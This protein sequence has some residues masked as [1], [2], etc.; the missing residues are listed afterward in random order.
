[1]AMGIIMLALAILALTLLPGA[2]GGTIVGDQPP[3][4]GEWLIRQDT[5]VTDSTVTVTGPVTIEADLTLMGS[6]LRISVGSSGMSGIEV[7]TGN[8]MANDSAIESGNGNTYEFLV[9]S[10]MNLTRVTVKGAHM[11]IY[12]KTKKDVL[13]DDVLITDLHGSALR[14]E[15]AD[16]TVVKDLRVHDDDYDHTINRTVYTD[17]VNGFA[18]LTESLPGILMIMGGS[19]TVGTVDISING[20]VYYNVIFHQR[21][22][23][24]GI[25]I[26]LKWPM[27]DVDTKDAI[28]LN[29]ITVRDSLLGLNCTVSSAESIPLRMTTD[30]RWGVTGVVFRNYRDAKIV[31]LTFPNLR[32]DEIFLNVTSVNPATSLPFSRVDWGTRAVDAYVDETFDRR[33]PHSFVLELRDIYLRG[34][35]LLDHRLVPGYTGS[36]SPTFN[37]KVLVDNAT[38]WFGHEPIKF[39]LE[40]TFKMLKT[41]NVD[42][43]LS[44]CTFTSLM[45]TCVGFEY[46]TGPPIPMTRSIQLNERTV[47]ENCRFTRNS[48]DEEGLVKTTTN[49]GFNNVSNSSLT[50]SNSTFT[51]N[52]GTLFNIVGT[53]NPAHD[54]LVLDGNWISNNGCWRAQ[55][56]MTVIDVSEVVILNNTFADN[57]CSNGIYISDLGYKGE[58]LK[59]PCSFLI[60]NNSFNRNWA[61][62]D[63]GPQRGFI[64]VIW[65]GDLVVR[66]NLINGTGSMFLNLTEVTNYSQYSTLD[67]EDN[68]VQWNKDV[69]LYFQNND[70][71]HRNLVVSVLNNTVWDNEGALVDFNLDGNMVRLYDYDATFRLVGNDVRRARSTVFSNYGNITISDNTFTDCVG[72]VLELDYLR[73]QRPYLTNNTFTRCGDTIFIKAK[74]NV[75]APILIWMD[76]NVIDTNGTA[77]YFSQMEVTLRTTVITSSTGQAVVAHLS[78]VDAYDCDFEMDDCEVV[79]DGYIKM[80]YWVEAWVYWASKEGV[81]TTNPVIDGNVTFR[82]QAGLDSVVAYPDDTGHLEPAEVLAWHIT[83]SLAPVL[84]NPYTIMVSLSSFQ[85]SVVQN[86]SRSYKGDNALFLY[87]WDP[88]DPL[89]SI[90]GPVDMSAHNTLDVNIT[91]FVTDRGSGVHILTIQIVGV[92]SETV[93]PEINGSYLHVLQDVPEGLFEI[94]ATVSD[95][96][97]NTMSVSI[98]IE[99]DRTPPRLVVTH[100][101]GELFTNTTQVNIRGEVEIGTELIINMIEHD[102]STGVIDLTFPL[103]EGVNYFGLTA[104]DRAGNAANVVIWVTRDTF[105]PEL[106]LFGPSD[107]ASVNVSDVRVFGLAVDFDTLTITLH[108][109]FTD[110][111]DRP[112]FPNAEGAFDVMA[113]LEEGTNEIVVTAS[114]K[115]GNSITI[116]RTVTMDTTPPLLEL[117]SPADNTLLNVHQVTVVLTVSDDADQVYV[118]G[119]RVL[120]TGDLETVVTLG[121]GENPITIRA[122]DTLW[123]EASTSIMVYTDTVAPT[124]EITEPNVTVIMTND[125][126]IEVRGRAIDG[127][128][129]GITVMVDGNE[130]TVTTDGKFYHLLTLDEDGV[131]QVEV[132]VRDRAGNIARSAFTVDL[133]TEAPLMNLIFDPADERVDPG[134][135]LLI[136]GAATGLPLT[137]TIIHDANGDRDEFTFVMINA[138]FEHYLDLQDGKNTITVRSVDGYGNWNVTAPYVVDAREKQEPTTSNSTTLFLAIAIVV[139]VALIGT[140]YV[141]VRRRP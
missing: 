75:P 40:P 137:V 86:I 129:N 121:E 31:D 41:F 24:G 85:S 105:V 104:T 4:S 74:P 42:N 135:M 95:A 90:D 108:R 123:N 30:L 54:R 39:F 38:A 136:L 7:R 96:G 23:I 44:N 51:N 122:I 113:E 100:P 139:A 46:L 62:P 92:R 111:I 80:W 14:L 91:G 68:L 110:I 77:I 8:L 107:E 56:L 115:A 32:R 117:V 17:D 9:T 120:G 70:R 67:F 6:T 25:T 63:T 118:N 99:V 84:K 112:L 78:K 109:R 102:T 138:T 2:M 12:V 64:D 49:I 52:L 141:L 16:K 5:V 21:T 116:R 133:R 93:V 11:G 114:D 13:I 81:A 79:V 134:T 73:L 55:R 125:P 97:N 50:I 124:M 101:D 76:N 45:S 140:A 27:V 58:F 10:E 26:D 119:K 20:T 89:V 57:D 103:N 69:V 66:D 43:L 28:S 94:R 22:T 34:G 48:P 87:L 65:G 71:F 106:E 33:G 126:V 128:L 47:L 72:W 19:P 53:V 132:V 35:S 59:D 127:D 36:S 88:E 29:D 82:D 18:T 1:M 37:S 83:H 130:A 15:G 3:A 131:H 61:V 98:T 60:A